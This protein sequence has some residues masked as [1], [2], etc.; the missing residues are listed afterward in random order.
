MYIQSTLLPHY[1]PAETFTRLVIDGN[2]YIIHIRMQFY[3]ICI[4]VKP[5]KLTSCPRDSLSASNE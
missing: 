2:T 5:I 3:Y 4:F 1:F